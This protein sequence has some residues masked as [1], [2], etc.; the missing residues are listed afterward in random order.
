MTKTVFTG[1]EVPHLFA[2]DRNAY[3]RNANKTL[4]CESGVLYSYRYSAPIAAWFGDT[5]LLNADSYSVT[6]SKHQ[7]WTQWAVRHLET[8]SMPDLRVFLENRSDNGRVEYIAK[9]V[10]DI[11]ALTESGKKLRAEWKKAEN[12]RQIAHL[13]SVCAFVWQSM[14]KKSNWRNSVKVKSA[15]D[16]KAAIARYQKSRARLES[17]MEF[18]LRLVA[19]CREQIEID[20]NSRASWWRLENCQRDIRGIDE[21]GARNGSATFTHAVKL[22]GV[23]WAKECTALALQIVAIADSLQP[24]IDAA[25]AEYDRAEAVRNAESIAAWIAGGREAPGGDT[26]CRVIGDTV[27][28][29]RGAR[30]PLAD[31]LRLVDLARAC[32]EAGRPMDLRGK[33]IG[34]YHAESI[35]AQGDLK[36]GCHHIKWEA[37]ADCVARY[38]E[39]R[40]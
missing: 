29:S 14:G 34:A 21:M 9:R 35:S 33:K 10:K 25:L 19:E 32:R 1:Q 12:A 2:A 7:R 17:G 38:E 16:K 36:I 28:T 27:E 3:A 30:V 20:A 13:E 31:A 4:F 39:S 24:E 40:A 23:K 8:F 26:I 15:N 11:E 6:T 37:I 22:M 18:A 5:V